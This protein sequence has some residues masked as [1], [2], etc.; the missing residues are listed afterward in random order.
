MILV[1]TLVGY[2]GYLLLKSIFDWIVHFNLVNFDFLTMLHGFRWSY[3]Y[4]GWTGPLTSFIIIS[5]MISLF[6]LYLAK[7]KGGEKSSLSVGYLYFIWY[8]SY[9]FAF[10][11]IISIFNRFFGE[12]RWKGRKYS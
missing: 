10:W 5:L 7:L 11:W 8:Y 1:I 4:Y 3:I 9:L 12:I 6:F 2:F